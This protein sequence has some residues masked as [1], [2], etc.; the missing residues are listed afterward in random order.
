MIDGFVVTPAVVALGLMTSGPTRVAGGLA[1]AAAYEI[2][3]T[4]WQGRTLG[5]AVMGTAV[6][7]RS[8]GAAPTVAQV[9]V[10]WLVLIAGSLVVLFVPSLG[11]LDA[12]YSL[13]V[14][15]PVMQPPLHLGMHDRVARTIVTRTRR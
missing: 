2:V 15:A 3:I 9:S 13:V 6:V 10:R 5:K 14:L 7:D 8:T 4:T 11:A 1:T 12:V